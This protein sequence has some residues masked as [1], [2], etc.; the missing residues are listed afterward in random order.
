M[1]LFEK[2]KQRELAVVEV[3]TVKYETKLDKIVYEVRRLGKVSL[4][5]MGLRLK[6]EKAMV[7]NYAKILDQQGLIKLHY[8]SI[9]SPVLMR[10][11]AIH[12]KPVSKKQNLVAFTLL[13]IVVFGTIIVLIKLYLK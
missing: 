10:K 11:E 6:M 2:G 13:L 8:P 7:E 3:P 9:G 1:G 4:N 12:E 5:E